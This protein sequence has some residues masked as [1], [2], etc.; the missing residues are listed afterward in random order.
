MYYIPLS[1]YA[2]IVYMQNMRYMSKQKI[3]VPTKNS[4]LIR[5]LLIYLS[6]DSQI[7]ERCWINN[8]YNN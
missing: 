3:N 8:I 1:K 7:N 6:S 4:E 2:N 5:A